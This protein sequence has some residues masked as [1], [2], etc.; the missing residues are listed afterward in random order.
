MI[1]LFFTFMAVILFIGTW[2]FIYFILR[3][4]KNEI[5]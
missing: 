3:K 5:R 4:I 2:D 1:E